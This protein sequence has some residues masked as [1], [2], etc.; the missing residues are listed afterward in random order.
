MEKGRCIE[1]RRL[2]C[3]LSL[4]KCSFTGLLQYWLPLLIVTIEFMIEF[5]ALEEVVPTIVTGGGYFPFAAADFIGHAI[6][7]VCR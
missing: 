4:L 7:Y 3:F 2:H 6:V 5:D 1:T